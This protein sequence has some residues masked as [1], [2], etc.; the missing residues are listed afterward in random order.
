MGGITNSKSSS[1]PGPAGDPGRAPGA[2]V[3]VA[4]GLR[5]RGARGELTATL[6][7]EGIDQ[8]RGRDWVLVG[9]PGG[10]AER[11]RV[12]RS[13]VYGRRV[14]IKLQGI[15]SAAAAARLEGWDISLPCN[16]LLDLPDGAYYIFELV[17]LTVLTAD[18]RV[19]GT[20]RD[21]LPTGGTPL[22][23]VQPA[24]GS[25]ERR[26]EILLP[27]ARSICRVIDPASGR[28]V[29]DPPEGL[30]ELYGL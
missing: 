28:I 22:L 1:D 18:G 17:G 2:P 13:L 12:E 21:V 3:V 24:G 6:V 9:P 15:D 25:R 27:A 14:A 23:C 7:P 30:L 4:R 10:T 11:Q 20:V 26:E 8:L 29:I 5:L 19:I 16:G